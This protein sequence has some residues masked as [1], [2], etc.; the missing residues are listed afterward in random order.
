M[1]SFDPFALDRDIAR[2]ARTARR[3]RRALREDPKRADEERPLERLR[4]VA[5]K[6]RFDE[7]SAMPEGDPM[8]EPL[9]RWVF[10]LALLRI[11][12]EP[13]LREARLWHEEIA[14]IE[15][16]E[17][18]VTSPRELLARARRER[19]PAKRRGWIDALASVAPRM[20]QASKER[21]EA[22][23]E[24]ASR[25][26]V[27]DPW[28]M[29]LPQDRAFIT[30]LARELL[31]R[32]D[33]LA[34]QL[35][36]RAGDLSG[37]IE[38]VL[39][40]DVRGSWPRSAG[41]FVEALF[42]RTPLVAGLSLDTGP[43]P[44]ALGASSL[45]RALARFGAAHARAAAPRG[46][47]FVL[48]NDPSDLAPLR[49]G[50]LFGSLLADP[51]FLRRSVG[52]SRDEAKEAG[53]ILARTLLGALRLE[54]ARTVA[55][56]AR[57]SPRDLEELFARALGIEW[58]PSLAHVLPRASFEAPARLLAG[59]LAASEREGLIDR[60]DEDWFRNPH[61]LQYL[62]EDDPGLNPADLDPKALGELPG[63]L[64]KA[65]EALSA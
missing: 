35:F 63:R 15:Q 60:F 33:D 30:Q 24:I 56:D 19:I 10:E 44:E 31:E 27:S 12:H 11:A 47:P 14:R 65:L 13:I 28:S 36:G 54:A 45:I 20:A 39:A 50:A 3:F 34:S 8:R 26:G 51:I 2:A 5:G 49:R 16:P 23:V 38:L 40:R 17:K 42:D 18:L 32:T 41:R 59:L 61:A 43:M 6:T 48:A 1:L 29:R 58:P 7:V 46:R 37:W 9:R 53:R 55:G 25:M 57:T 21:D 4:S 22:L 62:R 64:S 52:L